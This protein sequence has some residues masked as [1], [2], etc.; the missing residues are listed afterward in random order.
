MNKEKIDFF[1]HFLFH[2]LS[3]YLKFYLIF[4][5]RI[6]IYI[7]LQLTLYSLYILF[8]RLSNVSKCLW[9]FNSCWNIRVYCSQPMFSKDIQVQQ[10]KMCCNRRRRKLQ[11]CTKNVKGPNPTPS[12]IFCA[13]KRPHK[14]EDYAEICVETWNA[15]LFL[16]Q[17]KLLPA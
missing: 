8:E 12:L 5:Q 10:N 11:F 2:F 6:L 13:H 1:M 16:T 7:N 17:H 3:I 4:A 9:L 15:V 14:F